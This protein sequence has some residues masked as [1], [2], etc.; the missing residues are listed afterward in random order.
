MSTQNC[1]CSETALSRRPATAGQFVKPVCADYQLLFEHAPSLFLVLTPD[2]RI[3]GV[4]DEYLRATMTERSDILGRDL[5]EVFPDNPDDPA[6][7]GTRNLS[8]SLDR[9]LQN[10]RVDTMAVQK[11]DIRRPDSEGGEFEERFWSPLNSPI[12]GDDGEVRYIIHRVEDVTE[13]VRLRQSDEDQREITEDLRKRLSTTETEIFLRAQEVQAVNQ[14]LRD[15]NDA[16]QIEVAERK[17]AEIKAESLAAK[18]QSSNQ[19]L[20][21]ANKELEA[22]SYSVSHDLRC[23][24][25]TI[26][27]YAQ[28]IMAEH[29][30]SLSQEAVSFLRDIRQGAQ[31]MGHL[32]DDLLAFA[33]LGRQ[34]LKREFCRPVDAI[35]QCLSEL[36]VDSMK[37][38]AQFTIGDLPEYSVDPALMKQVWI[39]LLSNA[40]KYSGKRERPCIEVGAQIDAEQGVV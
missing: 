10:R 37:S 19:E 7:T 3:V 24:L 1:L 31:Q 38:H 12:L 34:R 14:Q 15:A 30:A 16:L 39:N 20:Q 36:N 2:L 27:G 8:A 28:I 22:F 33:R 11:Y 13:F 9:V 18:L 6:A 35:P 23:P 32:V 4:S 5:F 25:R 21:A 26:D 17:A 40:L 29:A